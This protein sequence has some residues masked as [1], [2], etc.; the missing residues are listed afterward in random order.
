MAH[1]MEL[2]VSSCGGT[3]EKPLKNLKEAV[4]L[5]LEQAEKMALWIRSLRKRATASGSRRSPDLSSSACSARLSRFRRHMPRL[6]F[7]WEARAESV[8]D[9]ENSTGLGRVLKAPLLR[10]SDARRT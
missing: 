3:K 10:K 8:R 2:D 4:R 9:I 1:A 5:F 7:R 6:R